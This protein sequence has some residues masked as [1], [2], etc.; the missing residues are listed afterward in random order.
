MEGWSFMYKKFGPF[1]FVLFLVMIFSFSGHASASASG[2]VIDEFKISG[3]GG[4]YD[5]YIVV[6]NNGNE[7]INLEGYSLKKKTVSGRKYDLFTFNDFILEKQRKVLIS[8]SGY[9]GKKDYIYTNSIA[10]DNT[11]VIYDKAGTVVDLVG[12]GEVQE[13]ESKAIPNPEV[14]D[15]YKRL[16]GVDTDNN[17]NDFILVEPES[18]VD[19]NA[20][21]IIFTEV[22]PNPDEGE[23]WFEIYNPTNLVINLFG[24]KV[25][26]G[27]GKTHCYNFKDGETL[28]P[29]SYVVF[30]QSKTKITLNN[31][32]DWL[33]LFNDEEMIIADTYQDFGDSDR[34]NSFAYFS[35]GWMWTSTPSKALENIFTDILEIEPVKIA[36]KT[37]KKAST[38]KTVVNSIEEDQSEDTGSSLEDKNN[39]AGVKGESAGEKSQNSDK[40]ISQK[41]VGYGIIGL[42]V[43]ILLGYTLWENKERISE[44]YKRFNRKND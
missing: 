7:D 4:S 16:N 11:L 40:K 17:Y 14:N 8:G 43:V 12:Y 36:K 13:Y 41:V 1:L 21:K 37:V 32:G 20:D 24:L 29:Y 35:S 23:E 44:F 22:M 5:E 28:P 33:E 30:E 25:C 39:N 10:A 2:L 42:A 26:D 19:I 34:G 38:K 3:D 18:V 27:A 9:T 15:I 6:A 31:D